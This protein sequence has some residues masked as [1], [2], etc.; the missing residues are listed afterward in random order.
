MREFNVVIEQD[1]DGIYVASVPEL[2]GCHTQAKTLDELNRRIKEAIELYL[3][4]KLEK[5][6]ILHPFPLP[7]SFSFAVRIST[8]SSLKSLS[9]V[10]KTIFFA[11]QIWAKRRSLKSYFPCS[12]K[13]I[14][15]GRSITVNSGSQA[16]V[17]LRIFLTL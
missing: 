12:N 7:T 8:P 4:V 10:T 2:P 13:S 5:K 17:F 16:R 9:W 1:K 3:E 15:S 11:R 6:K 14:I